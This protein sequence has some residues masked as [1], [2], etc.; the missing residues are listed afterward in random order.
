MSSDNERSLAQLPDKTVQSIALLARGAAELQVIEVDEEP[1]GVY[2]LHNSLTGVTERKQA[3]PGPRRYKVYNLTDLAAAVKA[4]E[5]GGAVVLIG[6][7]SIDAVMDE[8]QRYE[9]WSDKIQMHLR[10]TMQYTQALELQ[11]CPQWMGQRKFIDW[12]RIHMAGTV[13]RE[14]IDLFRQLKSSSQGAG[15]AEVQTGKE[16]VARSVHK[17]LKGATDL[18]EEITLKLSLYEE[19]ADEVYVQ[20]V[21]CALSISLDEMSFCLMPLAGELT[22]ALRNVQALVQGEL[23]AACGEKTLVLCGE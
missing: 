12:L 15:A 4:W 14:T 21:R 8:R 18:P 11:V 5:K 1:Y 6:T 3:L 2:Y 22:K 13:E 17:E 23:D 10:A 16:S 20:P 9:Q 19:L 7:A